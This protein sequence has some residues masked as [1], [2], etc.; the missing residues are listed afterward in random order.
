MSTRTDTATIPEAGAVGVA[1]AVEEES[2]GSGVTD[3][4]EVAVA[5]CDGV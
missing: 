4:V 5:V 1:V 2:G 3:G